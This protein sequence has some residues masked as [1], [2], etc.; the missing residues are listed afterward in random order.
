MKATLHD[1]LN[2]AIETLNKK[3]S[4]TLIYE[5]ADYY[6]LDLVQQLVKLQKMLPLLERAKELLTEISLDKSA[7]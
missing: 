7:E 3:Y 4:N 1:A 2:L 5:D 6:V